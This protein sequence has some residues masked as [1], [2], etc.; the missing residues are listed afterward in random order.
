MWPLTLLITFVTR[1]SMNMINIYQWPS[2]K[3]GSVTQQFC[4]WSVFVDRRGMSLFHCPSFLDVV[5][6]FFSHCVQWPPRGSFLVRLKTEYLFWAPLSPTASLVPLFMPIFASFLRTR[7]HHIYLEKL[8][9]LA[10]LF[11]I[12]TGK[13]MLFGN[14]CTGRKLLY[15]TAFMSLA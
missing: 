7:W 1:S 10:P 5:H 6:R 13:V 4:S 12:F 2:R 3:D 8:H 14:E 9:G 11:I 15:V